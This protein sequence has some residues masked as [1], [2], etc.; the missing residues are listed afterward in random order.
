VYLGDVYGDDIMKLNKKGGR[1]RP[2]SRQQNSGNA[3]SS[4]S[5]PGFKSKY[6]QPV[7]GSFA[8]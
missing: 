7:V 5:K 3:D 1:K 6:A 8:S 2:Q 4:S